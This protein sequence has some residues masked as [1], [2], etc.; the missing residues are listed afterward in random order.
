MKFWASLGFVAAL[1][2]HAAPAQNVEQATCESPLQRKAWHTLTRTEKSLYIEAEKCLMSLPSKLHQATA[3]TRF[4]DFQM[5]HVLETPNVHFVGAFLPFHRFYM[6]AHEVAL[7]TECNYAGAQ[8]YWDESLDAGNFS[9]SIILDPESGF[10]GNGVGKNN[11][12]ADGPFKS[13]VN[14]IGPGQVNTDHCIDREVTDCASQAAS[15]DIVNACLKKATFQDMWN[16]IEGGPHG[17]GHGGIGGQM[18]NVFSSPGDPL[19]YLHHTW[20]DKLWWDW[21]SQ[22]LNIRL[23]EIGGTNQGSPFLSFN[24]TFPPF[25]PIGGNFTFPPF[26]GGPNGTIPGFPGNGSCSPFGGFP[27]GF[28]TGPP[29]SPSKIEDTVPVNIAGDPGNV[30]TLGHVLTVHGSIPDATISDVM[31]IQGSLL[32]YKYA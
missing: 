18:L 6:Y 10:G 2:A 1:A 20:L 13:Y 23:T 28:P 8:P 21:Q 19:F 25:P 11:C 27:G 3:R 22:N 12:I 24:G 29:S 4:D 15:L 30:T 7:R 14:A 17:A 9:T 32:C 5:T 26:P 16:C 31:N